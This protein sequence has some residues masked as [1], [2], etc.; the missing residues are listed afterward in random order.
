L[1][2]KFRD[3]HDKP[4]YLIAEASCNHMGSFDLAVELI[5]CAIEG[6]ADAVKFQAYTPDTITLKSKG[7]DFI[8]KDGPWKG[9]SLWE[10]Y[11]KTHTPFEWFPHLFEYAKKKGITAFASVFDKTS[12][13]MLEKLKC[14]MY[15]IASMEITDL[16]LIQYAAGTKKP[17][18][19]S[20]GMASVDEID[21]AADA[22]IAGSETEADFALLS[23]VS[24]YPTP[25]EEG[26]LDKLH[27]MINEYWNVGISDH[28]QG[29]DIPIAATA[30]GAI[31]IE[32]HIRIFGFS[33]SEDHEFS[34][35]PGEF[36]A[37]ANSVRSVWQSMQRGAKKSEESS[38]QLRRSLYVSQNIKAG[39]RFTE[40]NVRSVRPSYGMSPSM[41]PEVLGKK[42]AIDILKHTPLDARMIKQ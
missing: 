20:T 30:M 16:P 5:D 15:K 8:I 18:I 17:I 24:G 28:T 12:V 23:C 4:P 21:A 40:K 13:D 11:Q 29:R 1:I 32:K 27:N 25:H 10:L 19:L 36:R 3:F 7:P 42:A 37:M 2:S 35:S 9:R 34:M 38:R 26:G 22:V 33:G 31:I 6:G 14:P 41:M 39:E